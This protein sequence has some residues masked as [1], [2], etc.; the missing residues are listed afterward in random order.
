MFVY[1]CAVFDSEKRHAG[2]RYNNTRTMSLI[3]QKSVLS[4]MS[5][6]RASLTLAEEHSPEPAV[7]CRVFHRSKTEIPF[8]DTPQC[9]E[10]STAPDSASAGGRLAF[11]AVRSD[12]LHQRIPERFKC[13]DVTPCLPCWRHAHHQNNRT[14]ASQTHPTLSYHHHLVIPGVFFF[15]SVAYLII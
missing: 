14:W 13:R 2:M 7:D 9:F 11:S 12:S 6:H 1:T 8:Q 4:R 10:K 3:W 5:L 15:R